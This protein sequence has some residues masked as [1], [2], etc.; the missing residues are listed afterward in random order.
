MLSNST[1]NKMH[2]YGS[3]MYET[4]EIYLYG[5]YEFKEINT[6]PFHTV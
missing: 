4:L 6:I 5:G 2:I 1:T 3:Q